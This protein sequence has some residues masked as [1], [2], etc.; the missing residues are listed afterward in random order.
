MTDTALS[1]AGTSPASTP[2]R[3]LL[4]DP[5]VLLLAVTVVAAAALLPIEISHA[6]GLPAHPLLL[7]LPVVLIPILALVVIALAVRPTWRLQYGLAA[8]IFAFVTM[9]A[10]ILTAGAGE[11]LKDEQSR[12]GGGVSAQ[13]ERHAD[14]GSQLRLFLI[15]LAAA[16]I[17]LVVLDRYRA[18]TTEGILAL[19]AVSTVVAAVAVVV[20]V[21]SAIWVVR[22]GHLGAQITWHEGG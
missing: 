17:V 22:T 5:S 21:V 11:S 3:S 8:G 9:A 12:G 4:L 7:H 13:L 14:L 18:H 16:F 20:A 2:P 19:P 10:T 15:V 6:F 1:G